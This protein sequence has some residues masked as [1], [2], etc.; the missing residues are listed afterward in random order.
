MT[1]T[2]IEPGVWKTGKGKG[3]HTPKGRQV[4]D[5][6]WSE[7]CDLLGKAPRRRELLI[8]YLHLIQDKYGC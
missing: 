5:T 2:E 3:R 8:E 6:A 7:V 4:E 1:V